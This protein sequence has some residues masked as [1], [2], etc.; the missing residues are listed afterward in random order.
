MKVLSFSLYGDDPK[1]TYG[2]IENLKIKEREGLYEDWDTI[3]YY[4]DSVPSC[5][6]DILK[7][8]NVFLR[9]VNDCGI[10]PASWRF[11]AYDE[12][13]VERFVCRDADSR[14]SKREEFA[15]KQWEDSGKILHIMRDHPHHGAYQYGKPILGGMW[16]MLTKY[17]DGTP[18]FKSSFKD[19]ILSHQGGK[20]YAK[21]KNQWFWSDMNFLR[22]VVYSVFG[23]EETSLIHAAQDY[24]N[25]V[26]WKNESWA[27]DFPTPICQ[28]KYFVGEIFFFQD[29]IQKRDYQYTER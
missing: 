21:E 28:D 10:L 16:G 11:L 19:L 18:L 7:Q 17:Q 9:N 26:P 25:R 5:I 13:E 3:V 29:G 1:Y 12:V 15:V 20:N 4:D 22:D 14:I 8:H 2:L 24:M 27:V 6:L 23:K